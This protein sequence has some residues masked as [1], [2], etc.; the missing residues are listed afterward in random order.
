MI[1]SVMPY[2][3]LIRVV[4]VNMLNRF[5]D[6]GFTMF[7]Q[8]PETKLKTVL[9]YINNVAGPEVMFEIQYSYLFVNIFTTF[10]FGLAIPV[11]FPIT[12]LSLVNLYIVDR[13]ML[14]Y[15]YR[16]PPMFA[17]G[18]SNGALKILKD[19]PIFM[20]CFGYW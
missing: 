8:I 13:I 10:T 7:K 15:F 18:M 16:K 17:S 12:F 19:A 6:S 9:Q 20:L 2:I 5:K 1:Q 11:L 4:G 14:A 3:E